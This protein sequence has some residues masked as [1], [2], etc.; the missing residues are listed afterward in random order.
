MAAALVEL[1]GHVRVEPDAGHVDEKVSVD[2]AQVDRARLAAKRVGDRLRRTEV[3][4][5]LAAQ[6]RFPIRTG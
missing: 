3:D 6:V 5:E 1:R 2:L 4:P